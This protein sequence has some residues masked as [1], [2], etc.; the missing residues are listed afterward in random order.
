M[1][2]AASIIGSILVIIGLFIALLE[3]LISFVGFL[4]LAI[5]IIIVLA[6]IAVF[7]GVAFLVYRG[8][9]DRRRNG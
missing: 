8:W 4:A 2:K 1:I 7:A 5:K 3:A 6:F 9:Q